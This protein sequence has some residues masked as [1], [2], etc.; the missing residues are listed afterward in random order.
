V[1]CRPR[2]IDEGELRMTDGSGAAVVGYLL[3]A[4]GLWPTLVKAGIPGWGALIPIYNIYLIFK[5]GGV[6][7]IWMLFLLV[8]VLNF[9][10]LLWVAMKVAEAF[11]HGLVMG[12]LGLFLFAPLGYIVIG[13]GRSEYRRA[14][15]D[16]VASG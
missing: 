13:Y 15:F 4:I 1:W 16:T 7:A 9:F 14:R 11:G 6:S 5:L 12:V 10:V 2:D 8:P 3:L